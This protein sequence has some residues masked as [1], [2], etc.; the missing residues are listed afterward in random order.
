MPCSRAGSDVVILLDEAEDV[1]EARHTQGDT[2]AEMSKAFLNRMLETSRAPT[3]WTTNAV[4]AMD[5]ATVRRMSLVIEIG[6]PDEAARERI[7][8]RILDKEKLE[9]GEG[10]AKRLAKRWAAPAAAAAIAA[11]TARLAG[12][13]EAGLDVALG[14]VMADSRPR[15]RHG[16]AR[17]AG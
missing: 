2:R 16:P 4:Y 6:I 3:I 7:W 1:L 15:S 13:D 8:G 10:A 9:F 14:G 12:A 5:L 11:R 17:H